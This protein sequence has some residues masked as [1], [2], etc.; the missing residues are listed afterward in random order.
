[1]GKNLGKII[2]LNAVGLTIF[3]SWY[4]PAEHGFWFTLDKSIFYYFNEQLQPESSFTYFVGL[5][6]VRHFDI[7]SLMAML[8]L[9][10]YYYSKQDH[11]GKRKMWFIGV[12]ML[13]FA[14]ILNQLGHLIPVQRCSPTGFFENIHRVSKML[15]FKAKDYSGDSFPGDHGLM[16]MI[17]AGFMLRYFGKGSV[18]TNG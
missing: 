3:F 6:N 5:T 4:L 11:L 16:L 1:M 15:V 8:A 17:Y 14:V 18:T 7:I 13:F 12:T 10:G 9:Y 2:F